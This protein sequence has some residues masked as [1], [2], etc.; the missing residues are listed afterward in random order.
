[1][2]AVR[3][4]VLAA[5]VFLFIQ[6]VDFAVAFHHDQVPFLCFYRAEIYKF[7]NSVVTGFQ[8]RMFVKFCRTADM[9]RS[10]GQLGPRFADGLSGNN[11]DRFTDINEV[12]VRQV[13]SITHRTNPV[14]GTTGQNR[15]NMDFFDTGIVDLFSQRFI[16]HLI[17]RHDNFSA[18]RIFNILQRNSSQ[19][20]FSGGFN[21]FAA[22]HQS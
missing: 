4:D 12:A 6:H 9:K 21:D 10:H 19:N 2:G 11:T 15:P 17:G 1:M 7:H 20:T 5:N 3:Q 22:F 18:K 8:S 14:L 16:N 13:T